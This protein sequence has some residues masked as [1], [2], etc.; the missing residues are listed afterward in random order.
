[1]TARELTET[2]QAVEEVLKGASPYTVAPKY[3]M[4]PSALYRAVK[5]RDKDFS[6]REK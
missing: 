1:M 4:S 5:R 3:G 6:R 2:A